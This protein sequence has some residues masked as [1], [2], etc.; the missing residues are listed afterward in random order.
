VFEGTGFNQAVEILVHQLAVFE[1]DLGA[2]DNGGLRPFGKSG[3][4]GFDDLVGFGGRAEGDVRDYFAG[5]GIEY[6]TVTFGLAGFPFSGLEK[7]N[8]FY[9][10]RWKGGC[11]HCGGF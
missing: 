4:G 11:L 10:R 3:G 8:G 1:Q 6:L 2:L 7:G 5:G 9:L